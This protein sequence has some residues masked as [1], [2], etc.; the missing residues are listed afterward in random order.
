MSKV[1]IIKSLQHKSGITLS[2]FK[3]NNLYRST[4]HDQPLDELNLDRFIFEKRKGL[5][6]TYRT[7][8]IRFKQLLKGLTPEI[9]F[10]R[11]KISKNFILYINTF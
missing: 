11:E 4:W 1:Q 8:S 2:M 5:S 9:E 7:A 10:I 3:L 6:K